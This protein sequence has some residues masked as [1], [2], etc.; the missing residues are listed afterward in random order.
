MTVEHVKENQN[1][2]SPKKFGKSMRA[3][4]ANFSY[5]T[6]KSSPNQNTSRKSSE[7]W[8]KYTI[9]SLQK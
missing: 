5:K 6:I 2:Q 3:K 9:K 4:S 1:F 8:P 7:N